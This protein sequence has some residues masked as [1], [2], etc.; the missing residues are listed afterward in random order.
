LLLFK[1][2]NL[3]AVAELLDITHNSA[4]NAAS[5]A[6]FLAKKYLQL[7]SCSAFDSLED[8]V[9]RSCLRI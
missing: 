2:P 6:A 8:H 1:D 9:M 5:G 7:E 4:S 3:L